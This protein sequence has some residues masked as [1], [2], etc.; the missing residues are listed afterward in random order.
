MCELR[1]TPPLDT[2]GPMEWSVFFG[3]AI[4]WAENEDGPSQS[5]LAVFAGC[6]VRTVR[7]L[8]DILAAR[9]VLATFTQDGTALTY[10]P[11]LRL[12]P[13]LREH[14][15]GR[16]P[17]IWTRPRWSGEHP[18]LSPMSAGSSTD[19]DT[20]DTVP[21]VAHELGRPG[22]S[23]MSAGSSTDQDTRNRPTRAHGDAR[24][25]APASIGDAIRHNLQRIHV[26]PLAP[27]F[28][29]VADVR[30]TP[31]DA[32]PSDSPFL[33]K[34]KT[35][36]TSSSFPEKPP[37][38]DTPAP[39]H[40]TPTILP[41]HA[42]R[43]AALRALTARY[44][45]GFPDRPPPRTFAVE[46]IET[47]VRVT[48]DWTGTEAALDQ[49]HLDAL[50]G[51]TQR[52]KTQPPTV[53]FVW[54]DREYFIRNARD[55]RRAREAANAPKRTKTPRKTEPQEPPATLEQLQEIGRVGMGKM[56]CLAGADPVRPKNTRFTSPHDT[57]NPFE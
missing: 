6:S 12:G 4:G 56:D 31:P 57:R 23:P 17:S 16:D 49:E 47:L 3:I 24:T 55:I 38:P 44:G 39:A 33:I 43:A 29:P 2:V 50:A 25:L 46:D 53:R 40:R 15:W 14:A 7:R 52:S 1:R 27:S 41:D 13:V 18:G 11:G 30:S 21:P 10:R 36:T 34:K 22:L 9:G 8:V 5:E 20:D 19:Q 26:T 48:A 54:G 28:T 42:I 32:A 45:Q 35:L 51:A 37:D